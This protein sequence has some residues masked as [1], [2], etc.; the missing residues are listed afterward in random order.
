MQVQTP[1]TLVGVKVAHL[2]EV[3]QVTGVVTHCPLTQE[4]GAQGL[5]ETQ[6]V[7]VFGVHPGIGTWTQ[8]P[9]VILQESAVQGFA[10][11]QEIGV[12]MHP[13]LG[14]QVAV[15]HKSIGEQGVAVWLVQVFVAGLQTLLWHLL[16]GWVVQVTAGFKIHCWALTSQTETVQAFGAGGQTTGT[17]E[18]APVLGLQ[19]SV[20]QGFPSLQKTVWFWMHPLIGSQ[21]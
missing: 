10:S 21:T 17:K 5:V 15:W 3:S 19:E 1:L 18:Q 6:F 13:A 4:T 20:V 12:E 8:V 7:Q 9:V 2:L 11:S 16:D 14:S